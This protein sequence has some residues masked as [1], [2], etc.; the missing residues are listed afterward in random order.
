MQTSGL[1]AGLR[2]TLWQP[3]Q[4]TIGP[5]TAE[6]T[7]GQTPG[8]VASQDAVAA[9]RDVL[10]RYDVT[11]ITPAE[12]TEMAYRLHEAGAIT[13]TELQELAA[14]R[15]ELEQAGIDADESIDLLEFYSARVA[16]AERRTAGSADPEA[17]SAELA[18]LR[19]RLEWIEK[20]AVLHDT[21]GE[22]G[23]DTLV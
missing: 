10:A 22:L 18:P 11:D 3:A 9:L 4:G 5:R 20:L 19:Q 14:V 17:A 6:A 21:A 16:K 7:A 13:Q 1:L 23:L 12:F 8:P 15:L 2:D